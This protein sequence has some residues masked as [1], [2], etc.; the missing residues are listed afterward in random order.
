[1]VII[2][3]VTSK[4]NVDRTPALER[5]RSKSSTRQRFS[6]I[7]I[8]STTLDNHYTSSM[9][10]WVLAELRR[11]PKKEAIT[12]EITDG[13]LITY[14]AKDGHELFRHNVYQI[15]RFAQTNSDRTSFM[16]LVNERQVKSNLD[17]LCFLFKMDNEKSV[18][19]LFMTVKEEKSLATTPATPKLSAVPK[20][21]TR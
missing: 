9:M 11:N 15:S 10:P 12:L 17:L 16:Y 6:A 14:R 18:G 7:F 13:L 1:M 8:G 21:M 4:R 3:D 19:D 20:Q 5:K 2:M